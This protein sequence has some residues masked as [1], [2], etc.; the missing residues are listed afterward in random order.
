MSKFFNKLLD[1]VIG[2][3]ELKAK[4]IIADYKQYM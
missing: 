3:Q 2:S 4:K 1:L